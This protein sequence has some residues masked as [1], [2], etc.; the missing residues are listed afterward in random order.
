MRPFLL[1]AYLAT[2]PTL[3]WAAGA[4]DVHETF[5]QESGALQW[6]IGSNILVSYQADCRVDTSPS[7]AD[8][9]LRYK[10]IRSIDLFS[11]LEHGASGS[12]LPARV[13]EGAMTCGHRG[14][15]FSNATDVRKGMGLDYYLDTR[16]LDVDG[17]RVSRG[18]D[19]L[20]IDL[21]KIARKDFAVVNG[22]RDGYSDPIFLDAKI[23]L[24]RI[25]SAD[26]LAKDKALAQLE[27]SNAE[28]FEKYKR[29]AIYDLLA[30]TTLLAAFLL[31]KASVYQKVK[32][33]HAS[34]KSILNR[35]L[36]K[37]TSLTNSDSRIIKRERLTSYSVADELLKWAKLRDE[38]IVSNEEYHEARSKLLSQDGKNS[39]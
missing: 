10:L 27:S 6:D 13:E 5:D 12:L 20:A 22:H 3:G 36:S 21:P 24:S 18:M 32:K 34:L 31:L 37:L 17:R 19:T 28:I 39:S 23:G 2:I 29:I 38:G 8:M 9:P 15:V 11:I 4:I 33:R 14:L 1:V 30:F 26:K 35:Q 25:D 16:W 7:E